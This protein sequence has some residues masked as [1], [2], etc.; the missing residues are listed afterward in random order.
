[1]ILLSTLAVSS[2]LAKNEPPVKNSVRNQ[3]GGEVQMSLSGPNGI[4]FYSF[5]LGVGSFTIQE[6]IYSYYIKTPCGVLSGQM[7][8]TRSKTLA[9]SCQDGVPHLEVYVPEPPA[10]VEPMPLPTP[11][12]SN[13]CPVN[14]FGVI[15]TDPGCTGPQ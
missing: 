6:G 2:A 15:T 3:T 5:G 9:F 11:V 10:P 7:T 14:K 4:T 1:V 13:P 8:L 12:P